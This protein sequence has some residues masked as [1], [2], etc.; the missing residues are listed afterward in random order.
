MQDQRNHAVVALQDQGRVRE[1]QEDHVSAWAQGNQ[2]LLIVAD[3]MGG[4]AG[5]ELAS[6]LAVETVDRSLREYLAALPP[7]ATTRRPESTIAADGHAQLPEQPDR[8][9][10]KLPETRAHEQDVAVAAVLRHAVDAA[11]AAIVTAAAAQ[12]EIM[13][14]AGSTLTVALI[15]GH[16]VHI[17]HVGDSRAYRW[18]PAQKLRQL[19]HDHSGAAML[20][21]AGVISAKDARHHPESSVLYQYLGITTKPLVVEII[22]EPLNAGDLLLLCSDGLWSMVTDAEIAAL[23]NNTP[24]LDQLAQ[25]LIATA[26]AGG[27]EDNCTVVLAR[28]A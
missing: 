28:I 15:R 20:V 3:G 6:R 2:A 25:D 1:Q 27:G 14:D 5:G 11:Q 24:D 26:N 10:H 9:T 16:R 18:Q 19:T 22:H 23:I 4:H 17:A 13:S 21:A 8:T 12:P 7:D